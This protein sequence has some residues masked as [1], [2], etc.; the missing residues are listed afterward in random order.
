MIAASTSALRENRQRNVVRPGGLWRSAWDRLE[1][2]IDDCRR[3]TWEG[4]VEALQGSKPS[5]SL[6]IECS[7]LFQRLQERWLISQKETVSS[8]DCD[9]VEGDGPVDGPR[10]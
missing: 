1:A 8:W 10:W 7:P 2:C 9:E 5:K 6:Q 3:R 4:R